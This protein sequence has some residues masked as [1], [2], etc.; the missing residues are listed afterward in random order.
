MDNSNERRKQ[1]VVAHPELVA[2]PSMKRRKAGH[3]WVMFDLT[4]SF[5]N[6]LAPQRYAKSY[7]QKPNLLPTLLPK[8]LSYIGDRI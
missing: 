7:F 8:Y 3:D 4:N 6:W 5:P 1:W 2:K